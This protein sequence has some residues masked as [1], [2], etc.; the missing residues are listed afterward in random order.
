MTIRIYCR[1]LRPERL[2]RWAERLFFIVGGVTLGLC[3]FVYVQTSLFQASESK[4]FETPQQIENPPQIDSAGRG[5]LTVKLSPERVLSPAENYALQAGSALSKLEIPR[6][7]LSAVVVEGIRARDLRLAVGH[8]PGTALPGDAGNIVIAGHRD[9]F[10]RKLGQIRGRDRIV[11][12]TLHGSFEYS[13]ESILV[14]EPTNVQVLQ[15][16]AD[17]VLTLITCY[18]FS[19]LGPAPRR[20]VVQARPE[21]VELRGDPR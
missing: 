9:T 1:R 18:P 21:P 3:A 14:V 20:F 12:T 16:S 10:F 19:Y 6:L 17:P 5:E 4:L 2:L 11:L 15:S 8:I 7:G 13:V